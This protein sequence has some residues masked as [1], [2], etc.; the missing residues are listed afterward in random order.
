MH[1]RIYVRPSYLLLLVS[2]P[3]LLF[4]QTSLSIFYDSRTF[5]Q[6][7]SIVHFFF[8]LGI[9]CPVLEVNLSN[10]QNLNP[11][12]QQK[13]SFEP[14]LSDL[15]RLWSIQD[16]KQL[17]QTQGCFLFGCCTLLVALQ[18]MAPNGFNL[19]NIH[20]LAN[21]LLHMQLCVVQLSSNYS[22]Q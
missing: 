20:N 16:S 8:H 10:F 4:L 15:L 14:S 7:L 17:Q 1:I 3:W 19:L 6:H 9:S 13:H 12:L 18:Y 11:K 2:A 21:A 5:Q 22:H